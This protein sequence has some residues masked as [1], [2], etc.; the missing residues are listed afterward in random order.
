MIILK[1][2]SKKYN[3]KPCNLTIGA[4]DGIHLGH[5]LILKK[6]EQKK[7]RSIVV[8]FK[9]HPLS[10]L[11]PE[12]KF[13]LIYNINEKLKLLESFNIDVVILLEFNTKISNLNYID[14]LK[15]LK[16]NLSFTHLVVG[17]DIKI[18]KDQKGDKNSIKDL[19]KIFDFKSEFIQRLEYQNKIISSS[20]IR[21]L[22]KEKKYDLVEFLLNRSYEKKEKR[23]QINH[24]QQISHVE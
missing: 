23:C 24:F 14:F 22:I 5:Q 7:G 21:S 18:G 13:S 17:D 15:I 3:K 1:D 11:K 10:I 16:T 4:F 20:W 8:T 9:N 6:L 12:K 2:L 19:E